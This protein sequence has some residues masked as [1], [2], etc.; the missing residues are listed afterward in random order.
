[1]QT[2]KEKM[3]HLPE[4]APGLI[5]DPFVHLY[6]G[7]QSFDIPVPKAAFRDD[8][9]LEAWPSPDAVSYLFRKKTTAEE[10]AAAEERGRVGSDLDLWLAYLK[11]W[12]VMGGCI[13][14]V[15]DDDAIFEALAPH[16]D[17]LFATVRMDPHAGVRGIRRLVELHSKYPFIKSVSL[18]PHAIYPFIHPNSKEFYPIYAKCV[19]LDLPVFINVG[20]PGPRVPAWTQD[21][22]HLDEVCWFFPDL[23]VIMRHGGQPW[24]DVCVKLML[25][26]PNLY[27][28]TTAMAPKFY[29]KQ[30]IDYM[31]TRGSDKI[32]H[33]GYWPLIPYERHFEELSKLDLKPEVWPKFLAENARKAF[34]LG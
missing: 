22:M 33:C 24:E 34:R 4:D 8:E 10:V 26:W 32:I 18:S 2:S 31:N 5:V 25:R 1:M 6:L 11:K 23:T 14:S 28:A 9:S 13:L 29:P 3:M 30:I 16:K 12:N 7:K 15:D 21:P 17:E 20:F 27:Y 19:E